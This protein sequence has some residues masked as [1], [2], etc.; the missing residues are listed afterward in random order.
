MDI[1]GSI[2]GIEYQG[3]TQ[4]QVKSSSTYRQSRYRRR[5]RGAELLTFFI[6]GKKELKR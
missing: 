4:W 1:G 6:A 3:G 5:Q 2:E